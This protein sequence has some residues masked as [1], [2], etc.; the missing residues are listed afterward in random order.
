MPD[1]LAIRIR[2]CPL[3]TSQESARSPG[4]GEHTDEVMSE[5][6]DLTAVEISRLRGARVIAWH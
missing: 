4:I 6:L 3:W 1:V 5:V 2:F